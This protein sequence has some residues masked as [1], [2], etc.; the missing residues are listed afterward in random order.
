MAAAVTTTVRAS[1]QAAPEYP[2]RR[3]RSRVTDQL[4]P[5]WVHRMHA[6]GLPETGVSWRAPLGAGSQR[7]IGRWARVATGY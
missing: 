5:E 7:F 1:V 3:G 4:V 2:A 6:D